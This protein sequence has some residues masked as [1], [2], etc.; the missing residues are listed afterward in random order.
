M[1]K[2]ENL[3]R[4]QTMNI[5][6][7][8]GK[9]LLKSG[10]ETYRVEDTMNRICNHFGVFDV[11]VFVT[12]TIIIFGDEYTNGQTMVVRITYRSTNLS[13]ISFV[14]NFSY[15][16][17]S[18]DKDYEETMAFLEQKLEE[19][20]PYPNDMLCVA[21]GLGSAGFASM[22]GG[23][24]HD[25]L[26]AFL[27]GA[28]A[29]ILLKVLGGYRPSAFW[30]NVLAGACIGAVAIFCCA[31]SIQCT[32]AN[33]IVGAVMPFV[34]GVAFTNGLRDFMAGDLVSG[35]SRISEALLF[36]ISIAIGLGSSL[37]AWYHWGWEL[38]R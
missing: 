5:A 8:I 27:T 7:K 20:P 29:M 23:N 14:N 17:D 31:M 12:P 25:F 33:I 11:G 2:L 36:A 10:A 4:D 18:W 26:A 15:N 32:M 3:N 30:E 6:L 35:N 24:S 19:K 9:L 22:L 16:I 38:W 1:G 34:P 13:N 28:L 37:L 21:S